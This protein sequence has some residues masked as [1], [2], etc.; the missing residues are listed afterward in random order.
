MSILVFLEPGNLGKLYRYLIIVSRG[1]SAKEQSQNN[2][3]GK[4]KKNSTVNSACAHKYKCDL[5]KNSHPLLWTR[6][7][8]TRI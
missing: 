3:N 7:V 5:K 1:Q 2:T 4:S 8:I 6:N